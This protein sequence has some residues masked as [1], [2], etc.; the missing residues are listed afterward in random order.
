M[1]KSSEIPTR[2]WGWG[3][4]D[5]TYPVEERPTYIPFL[6]EKLGIKVKEVRVPDPDI[7]SVKLRNVRLKE[8]TLKA[9]AGVVGN[10]HV[11]TSRHDRV[12][13]G[14]GKSYRDLLRGHLEQ[15]PNPPDAVLFPASEK[16]VKGI[17]KIADKEAIAVVPFCGGS[18]VVGGVEPLNRKG[19]KG[20]I[21]VDLRRM[22]KVIHIDGESQTATFEAGIWGPELEEELM[23][24]G[25]YLG[26]APESFK[27]SGLGGWIASRSAGRQSTGYGKIEEMVKSVR[28]VTPRGVIDTLDVPASATGPDMDQIICGS[29]GTL[30]IITRA[31]VKVRPL[32]ESYDYRGLLFREFEGGV[33]AVR[34]MMQSGIVPETIRISDTEESALAMIVRKPSSNAA[35]EMGTMAALKVL[36]V[37]GYSFKRGSFAILGCEGEEDETSAR[38]KSITAVC[39]KHGAVPLGKSAGNEWYHGRYDHPYLRDIMMG[40]GVMIDTLETATTWDNIMNVYH[41]VGKAIREAIADYGSKSI[42]TCHLSHSYRT[43]S[44]L[45]FIFFGK[46][47][48]GREIE[49]W[50]HLKK[51]AGD[52]LLSSGATISHHHGVGYEHA[53]WFKKEYGKRGMGALRGLK[54]ELDPKG[55]MNP[56]KLGL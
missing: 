36:D 47:A 23:K 30:G 14:L 24:Q 39:R 3:D 26:H 53:P 45:Y 28:M 9:L 10:K 52:A 46:Q 18:S 38:M 49:Q 22:D 51:K 16:E 33:Q 7:E 11:S 35:K 29:E 17:L 50:E 40:W 41:T 56:G 15:V 19:L 13:H 54:K 8:A 4:I 5:K 34:E 31:T 44:S 25:L 6:E 42:V 32:P 43:G 48:K 12:Y 27:F 2:W 20:S 21:T 55:I 37:L 1:I